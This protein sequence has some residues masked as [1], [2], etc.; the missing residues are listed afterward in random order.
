MYPHERSLVKRLAGKPFA[1]L[2]VNSDSDREALKKTVMKEDL[3][4]RS[5]W[6]GGSTAGPIAETWNVKSWPALFILDASGIIRHAPDASVGA[7]AIDKWIDELVAE[8]EKKAKT[9]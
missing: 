2:G 9:K 8:T 3:T 5:W 4:W 1:L 7:E 6:D